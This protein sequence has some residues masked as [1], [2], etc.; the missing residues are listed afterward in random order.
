MKN[1]LSLLGLITL[2]IFSFF[3]TEQTIMV[4]KDMDD[5]MIELKQKS[6]TYNTKAISAKVTDDTLIPG[7]AGKTV[8]IN[9]SYVKIKEYGRFDPNLLV[10][11]KELPQTTISN[12]YNKFVISGNPDKRMVSLI[13]LVHEQDNPDKVIDILNDKE[14]KSTFF[15]DGNWLE[16]HV[17]KL[18]YLISSGHTVGNLSYNGNY[19]DSSFVWIDTIITKIGKQDK[20]YCYSENKDKKVIDICKLYKD[21]TIT[22][23]IVIENEGLSTLKKELTAGSLIAIEIND[24]TEKELPMYI[25]YIKSK[26]YK[27]DN[28]KNHLEE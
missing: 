4:V 11:K 23:N 27:L 20:S 2:F 5:T 14:V 15:V 8:D 17:E 6:V 10:Y 25:N 7:I 28:L 24:Q 1:F 26:G 13:F 21:T 9:K 3:Y 12:S 18:D 16:K 19:Q 22:P